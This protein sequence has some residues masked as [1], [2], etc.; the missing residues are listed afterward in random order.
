ML[1]VVVIIS[2]NTYKVLS[3]SNEG[4]QQLTTRLNNLNTIQKYATILVN[5]ETGERGFLLTGKEEFLEPYHNSLVQLKESFETDQLLKQMPEY[6][7]E[8]GHVQQLVRQELSFLEGVI[9]NVK[10]KRNI[11]SNDLHKSEEGKKIMD[12]IRISLQQL[13]D[14]EWASLQNVNK[15][16]DQQG[17]NITIILITGSILSLLILVSF[18]LMVMQNEK[19]R[20]RASRKLE[21]ASGMAVENERVQ[22][23]FLTSMSQELR[24]P[25]NGIIG[26]SSLMLESNLS[27]EQKKF[28]TTIHRSSMELLSVVNDI[29]DFSQLEAGKIRP[30]PVIFNIRTCIEEVV[31]LMEAV[32]GEHN[33]T[34]NIPA[35]YP[36]ILEG[37]APRIRQIFINLINH[38][39]KETGYGKLDIDVDLEQQ[40]ICDLRIKI[41]NTPGNLQNNTHLAPSHN[42]S[43]P[44]SIST[45]LIALMGG[46]LQIHNNS[47]GSISVNFNLKV[48]VAPQDKQASEVSMI[49]PP[50][51]DT[52]LAAQYP[53]KILS[54]DDN[55]M[56]QMV[57]TSVLMKLGYLPDVARNGEQAVV[58][59]TET[60]YDFIFMDLMMPVM[61]GIDATR[62]IRNF[63]LDEKFPVIVALSASAMPSEK[64]KLSNAGIND[65]LSKPFRAADIESVIRKWAVKM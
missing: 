64:D 26:M 61:N 13:Y 17:R 27:E 43:I 65:F 37:D 58:M 4:S 54:V 20:R 16:R 57:I 31:I 38:M 46:T 35:H 33:F 22:S 19:L 36:L 11:Q 41:K 6:A 42:T 18:Y 55:E 30:E 60:K 50:K 47:D 32:S 2:L 40:E 45:R 21:T 44:L 10:A 52:T 14:K 12:E 49:N 3:L 5:A 28:V 62:H 7:V 63:Y 34:L 29:I 15:W 56:N 9:A 8:I 1:A 25:M 48:K 53:L 24:T 59:S 39:R 51:L 23:Q